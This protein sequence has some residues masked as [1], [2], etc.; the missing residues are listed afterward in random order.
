MCC[1]TSVKSVLFRQIIPW[2]I[3]K[4]ANGMVHDFL[5]ISTYLAFSASEQFGGQCVS[6]ICEEVK[7]HGVLNNEKQQYLP[8]FVY[9]GR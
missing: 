3:G 7:R 2:T 4:E 5:L 8:D 9:E 6:T 1:E